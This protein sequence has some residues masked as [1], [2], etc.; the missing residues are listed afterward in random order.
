MTKDLSSSPM[1]SDFEWNLERSE[2]ATARLDPPYNYQEYDVRKAKRLIVEAPRAVKE[3][4]LLHY[5]EWL[6][7]QLQYC[8]V[9]PTLSQVDLGLPVIFGRL[10]AGNLPLDGWHRIKKALET[11]AKSLPV[12]YLSE[13]E[14]E[15][16]RTR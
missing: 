13:E 3:L 7:D 2:V 16:I 4:D 12:I 15:A 1:S 6:Q 10:P 5:G 8:D 9:S 11:G 14:T